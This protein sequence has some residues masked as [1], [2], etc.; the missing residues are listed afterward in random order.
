[1]I[2]ALWFAIKVA[3]AIALVVWIAE[4]P[5]TVRIEWVEYTVTVHVGLFLL[6]AIAFVLLTLFIYQTIKAFVDF[7]KSYARYSEIRAKEKGY[8]ALTRG[9][10]AVAAGD[11]KAAV[12]QAKRPPACCRGI[13]ACHYCSKRRQRGLK[14][15]KKM[16]S[17]ALSHCLN[18]K[19]RLFWAYAGCCKPRWM[20]GMMKARCCWR[21]RLWSCIP[22]RAGF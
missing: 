12:A 9:L 3:A 21:K 13:M 18:I 15:G 10:T 22:S 19:M 16:P 7:P 20:P 17:T 4:R 1:M 6:A 8:E 11:T 5:G 2:K 14:G